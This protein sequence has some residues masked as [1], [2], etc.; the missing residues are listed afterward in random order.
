VAKQDQE[1][2]TILKRLGPRNML[3]AYKKEKQELLSRAEEVYKK[4]ET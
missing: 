2:E 4:A 3:G 1:A